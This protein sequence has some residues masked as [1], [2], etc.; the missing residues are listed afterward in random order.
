MKIEQNSNF[1]SLMPDVYIKNLI[2]LIFRI[3][4]R[5]FT[6][7]QYETMETDRHSD[8]QT[9]KDRER[10]KR[11]RKTDRRT[12]RERERERERE[13]EREVGLGNPVL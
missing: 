7:A 12:E 10:K 5:H 8:S 1:L 3:G 4:D 9:R 2:K 13:K 11:E 6:Y